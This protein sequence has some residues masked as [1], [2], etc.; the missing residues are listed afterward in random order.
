MT[1]NANHTAHNALVA[2][3]HIVTNHES[4][5]AVA[6]QP[7]TSQRVRCGKDGKGAHSRT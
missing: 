5:V 2:V 7:H 4:G 1:T 3:C 6:L